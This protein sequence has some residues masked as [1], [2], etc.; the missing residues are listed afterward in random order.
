[1]KWIMK[2]LTK[3]LLVLQTEFGWLTDRMSDVLDVKMIW[4][5]SV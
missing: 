5:L 4:N 3:C 1:M 2:L